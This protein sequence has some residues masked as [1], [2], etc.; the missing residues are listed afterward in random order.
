M[1]ND[2]DLQRHVLARLELEPKLD[3]KQ[4]VVSVQDGV[5]ALAGSVETEDDRSMAERTVKLVPGVKG[6][7]DDL[8]VGNTPDRPRTDAELAAAGASALQWLT[9]IPPEKVSITVHNAWL[10]LEGTVECSHQKET[11][12]DLMWHLSGVRGVD[13]QIT[14]GAPAAARA[15]VLLTPR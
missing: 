6:L 8:R 2:T 1:N 9:T 7:I 5:V 11:I 13:N 4:I 12:E 3:T 14:V 10:R 15:A